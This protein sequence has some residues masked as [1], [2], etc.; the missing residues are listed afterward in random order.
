MR[1]REGREGC[2]HVKKGGKSW[3]GGNLNGSVGS[4]FISII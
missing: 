2:A 3:T 4:G 1:L